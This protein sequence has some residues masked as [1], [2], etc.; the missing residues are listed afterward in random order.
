MYQGE[1]KKWFLAYTETTFLSFSSEL[2]Q[3]KN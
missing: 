2:L 1:H 3:S